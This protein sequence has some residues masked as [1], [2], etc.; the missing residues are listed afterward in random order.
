MRIVVLT[1][2]YL[3]ANVIT[4]TLLRE[5]P[6]R[7]VGLIVSTTPERGVSKPV[8][9]RRQLRRWGPLWFATV[10]R[11]SIEVRTLWR[12]RRMRGNASLP[13]KLPELAAR[14]AI[15]LI[16]TLD[17]NSPATLAAVR[18]LTPDLLVSIYFNQ[19]LRR[20]VL[21]IAPRGAINLHPALLPKHR[22]PFPHFWVVATGEKHTG[23]TVHWIDERIDTGD[24]LQQR[25]LPVP[26]GA[27]VSTVM[28]MVVRPGATS[29]VEAVRL[30]DAGV[31][32]RK[33][34]DGKGAVYESWPTQRDLIRMWRN[35]GRYGSGAE[36]VAACERV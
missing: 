18:A 17:I 15:P 29:L 10:A 16:P 1:N 5:A 20:N 7:V 14:A 4:E 28:G 25:E 6:A 3:P 22:G 27:S 2:D 34:Q 30:I 32:P 19:R 23:I 8:A 31:A 35:G 11:H 26:A 12:L 21:A 24:I 9:L 36:V 13:P 33:P